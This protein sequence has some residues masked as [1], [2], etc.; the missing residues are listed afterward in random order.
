VRHTLRQVAP[1]LRTTFRN[2]TVYGAQ[3]PATGA[4][5]LAVML[6]ILDQV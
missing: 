5:M 2:S 3:L 4:V 1:A 6:N